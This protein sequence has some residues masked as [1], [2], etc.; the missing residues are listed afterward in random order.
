MIRRHQVF[1]NGETCCSCCGCWVRWRVWWR[2]LL[3]LVMNSWSLDSGTRPSTTHT[4]FIVTSFTILGSSCR[5][6]KFIYTSLFHQRNGSNK[7]TYNIINKENTINKHKVNTTTISLVKNMTIKLQSFL[8][9]F[10]LTHK[11]FI[12]SRNFLVRLAKRTL[13]SSKPNMCW[14]VLTNVNVWSFL[15]I[16]WTV[17][18]PQ[19]PVN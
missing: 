13:G 15:V 10:T 7:N 19:N 8:K 2:W 6:S 4:V 18:L 5:Y 3:E 11:F 17:Y 16:S 12:F 1:A 14:Q 9:W